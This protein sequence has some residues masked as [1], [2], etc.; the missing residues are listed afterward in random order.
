MSN[1]LISRSALIEDLVEQIPLAEN[2]HIFRDIIES[3]PTAY[4][5]DKVIRQIEEISIVDN[6]ECS[7]VIECN[8][9]ELGKES[10]DGHCGDCI[11]D[12]VIEIVKAGDIND[13]N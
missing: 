3:Q 6:G 7:D 5:V 13:T 4:D 12:F 10:C 1:D 8:L 11:I 9:S 2:V